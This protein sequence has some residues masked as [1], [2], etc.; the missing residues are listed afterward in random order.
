[1]ADKTDWIVEG[2]QFGTPNDAELAENERLRIE[3]L[4]E[5]LDY[6]NQEMVEAV[7]KK[8]VNNRVFKTPVGYEFLK[9]LQTILQ[10]TSEPEEIPA[11]PVYGVFSLR[12]STNPVVEK[13]KASRKKVK[14]KQEFFS[15]RTSILV[16]IGLALLVIIMFIISTTSSNPTVLNY[17]RVIQNRYSTWEQ[18]LSD[19]E[20]AVREKEKELLLSE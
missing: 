8:A 6:G 14:P 11:I 15:R 18:E 7:Y 9:Q 16:N 1:M 10:E 20:Q 17:E 4:E 12:E 3:R 19:R 2:F 13:I 5:K